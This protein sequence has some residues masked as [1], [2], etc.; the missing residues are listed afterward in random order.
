MRPM[1]RQGDV[2]VIQIDELP[3]GLSP[4]DPKSDSRGLVLA[5]GEATGHAHA[6]DWSQVRTAGGDG[7]ALYFEA[8]DS[9]VLTHQEHDPILLPPGN[10]RAVR[11]REYAPEGLRNVAD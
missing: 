9:A 2:L 3:A 10:Y 6:I 1:Y 7:S 8:G 5:E 4:L 11:Q